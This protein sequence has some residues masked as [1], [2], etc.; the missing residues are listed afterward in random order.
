MSETC[1]CNQE[2]FL[3]GAKYIYIICL[4]TGILICLETKEKGP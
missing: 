2:A 4:V 1:H 3:V